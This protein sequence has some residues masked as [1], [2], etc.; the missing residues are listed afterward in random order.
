MV[1]RIENINSNLIEWAITRAGFKL[2]DFF[3]KNPKVEEWI[4]GNKYPTIKQL[5][6][7]THKVHVPFGY[8]FL[9][10]PPQEE[11]NIPFFRTGKGGVK[12]VSLNIYHTV[13]MLQ[14]RQSWLTDYLTESG[15]GDLSFV[16]SFD[17][18]DNYKEIVN[19]IRK[20]LNL[21]EGWA[22][23]FRTWEETLDYLTRKIED[24][25]VIVTFNGVVG[26][27]TRRRID[28]EECR[29][30][31]LVNDKAPFL[32]INSADAKAAQMFTLIHELAHIWLGESAGFNNDNML[33]ADD[34]IEKLCD[35]VAAEF[36]VPETHF[37]KL[38]QT[39]QNF[40]TLSRNLKVSPIVVSRRALDLKLITKGEFF[41]FYNAYIKSFQLKKENQVS[42]GN[43]YATARKRVSLRFANYVNT[44]VKENNLLYRDAYRLTNLRGNTY[45]KFVNEY[46]YQ[47]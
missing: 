9:N 39:T 14:E 43:F 11:L 22:K 4:K 33:P 10:E 26:N 28:V 12:K 32:F 47:I 23:E 37:R 29:G 16:G 1:N 38:W 31:V 15:Y 5:E 18:N 27:N 8:L 35:K 46:L 41:E 6:E 36:L 19:D 45:E 24:T 40:K 20:T 30:F 44:A 21:N 25:G 2:E 7:F 3:A 17:E 34:P 42:G 13:Q